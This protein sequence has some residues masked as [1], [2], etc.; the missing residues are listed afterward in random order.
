MAR[1]RVKRTGRSP[2]LFTLLLASAAIGVLS[3]PQAALS[4]A[5]FLT[6]LNPDDFLCYMQTSDGRVLNLSKLCGG[7]EGTANALSTTDQSFLE[8]YRS[9]LGKRS[10]RLPAVKAALLQAQQNPQAVLQ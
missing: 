8:D 3:D 9:F 2:S 5:S 7:K 6:A 10:T 4:Q 1:K